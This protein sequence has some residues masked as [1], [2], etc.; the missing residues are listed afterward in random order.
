MNTKLT[1]LNLS[2]NK[3]G[4]CGTGSFSKVLTVST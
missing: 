2:Y 1:H 3:I 4:D